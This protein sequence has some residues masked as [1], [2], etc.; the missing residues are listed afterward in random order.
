MSAGDSRPG[1]G[2]AARLASP[3]ERR[4]RAAGPRRSPGRLFPSGPQEALLRAAL[5]PVPEAL[6]AWRAAE[7]WL[8]AGQPDPGTERLLPLVWANL[9]RQGV[10]EPGLARLAAVHEAARVHTESLLARTGPVLAALHRAGIPTLVLKGAAL[11]AGYYG[12][13]GLRPMSD[14][15][16]LVPTG[17]ATAAAAVLRAEG[18]IPRHRWSPRAVALT[19]A[20]AF[21]GAG[22]DT[23]DLHW[24]VFAECCRPGDD[25]DFWAQAVP[26][27]VGGVPTRALVPAD[28]LLHVLVH[29]EKWVRV[30]GIRW[31]ADAVH[32]LRSGAVDARR[33]VAQTV[34]RRFVLRVSRQL[35][36]LGGAIDPALGKDLLAALAAAPV[37][38]LEWLEQALGVRERRPSNSLLAHWFTHARSARLGL[39]GA[40]LSFPRYLLAIWHLEGWT[41]LPGAVIAR[42]GARLR[43][44]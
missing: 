18:W 23:L 10:R 19:H 25:E 13:A 28:Q 29:G 44:R 15:D 2:P 38:P 11:V 6:H 16:V 33:L 36:Y 43:R 26:A 34:R 3:D 27:E 8:G 40:A 17:A 42:A 12:G 39:A 14:L 7:G 37:S 1:P 31:V 4:W 32:V 21:D 22:G 41:G 5:L 20:A 30:P 9:T 24:H 35:A